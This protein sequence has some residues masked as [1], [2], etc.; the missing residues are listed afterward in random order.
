MAWNIIANLPGKGGKN[1][2][3]LFA[4]AIQ[5]GPGN[6]QRRM[7]QGVSCGIS[8]FSNSDASAKA[9][10]YLTDKTGWRVFQYVCIYKEG[11]SLTFIISCSNAEHFCWGCSCCHI[12]WR[13]WWGEARDSLGHRFWKE[14]ESWDPVFPILDL[15]SSFGG[16]NERP[17][18]LD[19]VE[20]VCSLNI[21]TRKIMNTNWRL[22]TWWWYSMWETKEDLRL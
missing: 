7:R 12:G 11:C 2:F 1:S 20:T 5:L 3:C 13:W 8:H 10:S 18:A 4:F 15:H 16:V 6:C 21:L 22:L 14:K 19:A 17:C 9:M